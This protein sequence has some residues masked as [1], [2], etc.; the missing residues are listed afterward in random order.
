MSTG[1]G[2]FVRNSKIRIIGV[3]KSVMK[4]IHMKSTHINEIY[5]SP[6]Y[7]S[8]NVKMNHFFHRSG[9]HL[10]WGSNWW[11][12]KPTMCFEGI[13]QFAECLSLWISVMSFMI[14]FTESMNSVS[15]DQPNGKFVVL[16]CEVIGSCMSWVYDNFESN[17]WSFDKCIFLMMEHFYFIAGGLFEILAVI[18]IQNHQKHSKYKCTHISIINSMHINIYMK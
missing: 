9:L 7:C 6:L 4:C 8:I 15:P 16:S 11:V 10:W 2:M 14:I 1:T 18:Y 17:V 13:S 3:V 12:Y 5:S